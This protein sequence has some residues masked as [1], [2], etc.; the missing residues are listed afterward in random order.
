[1]AGS[2][3]YAIKK[4]Y[5]DEDVGNFTKLLTGVFF[6]DIMIITACYAKK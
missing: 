6:G 4:I 2:L 3:F 5:Y 1:M